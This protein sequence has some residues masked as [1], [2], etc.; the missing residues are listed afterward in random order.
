[1]TGQLT[2]GDRV[3]VW[4]NTKQRWYK[5]VVLEL[6][7]SDRML[8]GGLRQ[9]GRSIKKWVSRS[10]DTHMLRCC[11]E[12]KPEP[13]LGPGSDPEVGAEAKLEPWPQPELQP[14]PEGQNPDQADALR[15]LEIASVG[16]G[17]ETASK[18]Q[19]ATA[20]PGD[21]ALA[22]EGQGDQAARRSSQPPSPQPTSPPFSCA[23]TSSPSPPS[24]ACLGA[25]SPA[26]RTDAE[27]AAAP[28]PAAT[29]TLSTVKKAL[30]RAGR[31]TVESAGLLAV[32]LGDRVEVWSNTRQCWYGGEASRLSGTDVMV[33][34]RRE[35]GG[36][37]SKWVSRSDASTLRR[38]PGGRGPSGAATDLQP[39]DSQSSSPAETTGAPDELRGGCLGQAAVAAAGAEPAIGLQAD[40]DDG[41]ARWQYQS[42]TP[43]GPWHDFADANWERQLNAACAKAWSWC[44]DV[45]GSTVK[46]R[47]VSHE[48]EQE[49]LFDV[50]PNHMLQLHVASN[51]ERA[52]RLLVSK[53]LVEATPQTS[54]T[55]SGGGGVT[56]LVDGGEFWLATME[57][58]AC[59][60]ELLHLSGSERAARVDYQRCTVPTKALFEMEYG[61]LELR[62]STV[63]VKAE[64]TLDTLRQHT[65]DEAV[66][67]R[68]EKELLKKGGWERA[69]ARAVWVDG[70][71]SVG[72]VIFLEG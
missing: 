36:V 34:G 16:G 9:K 20:A 47:R 61:R 24:S 6:R 62:Q 65:A 29:V 26:E 37:V 48:F 3:D 25:S 23:S 56:S 27:V 70:H 72:K 38:P 49:Y 4:S 44:T 64:A 30:G 28:A 50:A 42:L 68:K 32:G 33:T 14:W 10:S 19:R 66:W 13:E 41:R 43:P 15:Q 17:P 1:M 54:S 51:T 69:Y 58:G 45:N 63:D 7:G 52:I 2:V 59:R 40:P 11:P 39:A 67:Q 71:S 57:S 8:V 21:L 31:G 22:E 18:L 46:V 53:P 5:C 60:V 12:P 35:G 55:V